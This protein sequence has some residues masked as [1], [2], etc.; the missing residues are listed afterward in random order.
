MKV[1]RKQINRTSIEWANDYGIACV[2]HA[3][4]LVQAHDHSEGRV[5][6]HAKQ[7]CVKC[8]LADRIGGAV[9]TDRQC[10]LCGTLMHFGN[11]NTD[12][13]CP[14]CAKENLLCKHCGADIDL[15]NRRKLRSFE[16]KPK[17]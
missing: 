10:G 11:T 7:L 13:L 17:A 9:M 12:V 6:R 4:K 3:R 2:E 1:D 15:K 5:E 16:E 14:A 8:Y